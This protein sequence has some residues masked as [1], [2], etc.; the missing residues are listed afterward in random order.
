M[1][2][3]YE[4]NIKE[5]T[6]VDSETIHFSL[7]SLAQLA[8]RV[9]EHNR[10]VKNGVKEIASLIIQGHLHSCLTKGSEAEEMINANDKWKAWEK[11]HFMT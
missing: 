7:L 11:I 6:V 10:I 4:T 8:T 2:A 9:V 1:R 3:A 5:F